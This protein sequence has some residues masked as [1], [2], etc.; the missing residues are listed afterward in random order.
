[1]RQS[2]SDANHPGEFLMESDSIIKYTKASDVERVYR[3]WS[4][5][6][7]QKFRLAVG[8]SDLM[9]LA[10]SDCRSLVMEHLK[11]VRM[12]I[13]EYIYH[14]PLFATTLE[15][16]V[17]PDP[18]PE[19]VQWMIDVST[20]AGVGPM[21]AVAG[22]VAGAIGRSIAAG[23]PDLIIENG[24]D[25]YFRSSKN[26]TV[27]IYAGNSP[28]SG[29]VGIVIPPSPEFGICTSAG[30]VGPSLSFGR[31]DAAVILSTDV[32]LADA[33]ATATAN[34]VTNVA[35][36]EKALN[37]A[38]GLPGVTGVLVIKDDQLAVWGNIELTSI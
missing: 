12:Q 22:A 23:I 5:P 31:A 9:I 6:D 21:A 18:A 3:Q 13:K 15:P 36:L 35:D 20:V 16:F 29:K 2:L 27:S 7:L 19:V 37:F 4:A 11:H 34:R 10:S 24:G 32:A 25:I 28:L 33:V 14:H 8:E 30:T 1:L 38:K 26:R 17:S